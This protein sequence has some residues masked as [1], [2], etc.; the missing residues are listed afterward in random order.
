[1]N[2]N[3][4]ANAPLICAVIATVL[5]QLIK[6]FISMAMGY[7]FNKHMFISTGGMPSSHS[8]AVTALTVSIALTEGVGS[9]AFAIS[10]ALAMITM[11]DAMGIRMEAGKQAEVLNEWSRILSEFHEDGI[12]PKNL[13]TMLGH[14]FMQVLGGVILGAAV[15]LLGTAVIQP[16]F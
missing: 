8:S 15:A 6:P 7:K 1:M 10:L 9:V 13:K 4:L 16:W 12:Q 5:A 11:H 3:I 14:T 2:T